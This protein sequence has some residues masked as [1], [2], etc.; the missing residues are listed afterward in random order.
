MASM[1]NSTKL[2]KKSILK[3]FQNVERK[4]ILPNS[5]YKTNINPDIQTK[6]RHRCTY[7]KKKKKEKRKL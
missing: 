7:T 1:L 2:L 3:L 5:F 4:G 6:Q